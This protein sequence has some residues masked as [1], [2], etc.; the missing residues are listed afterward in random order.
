MK[1]FLYFSYTKFVCGVI[2]LDFFGF[3]ERVPMG[4]NVSQHTPYTT[5][6]IRENISHISLKTLL[7]C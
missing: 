3:G 1:G 5:F 6:H 7:F 2:H 4:N